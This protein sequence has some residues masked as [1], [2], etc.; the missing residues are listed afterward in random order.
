MSTALFKEFVSPGAKFRGSPFW[1][2]N[3]KLDPQRIR[4]QVNLM[5]E[6]GF[7]GFFMHSRA[8]LDTVYFSEEYFLS[9]S[10]A[11]DEARKLGLIPWLYDEDRWPSGFA[12]GRVT[13]NDTFKMKALHL[14]K[15]DSPEHL[16]GEGET[17][18]LFSASMNED[19]TDILSF[20]PF[21]AESFSGSNKIL[22]CF[23]KNHA[24]STKFNN[25]TYVDTLNPEAV[26]EFINVTHEEFKR[27]YGAEFG[28]LIPGIFT[29]EPCC[30]FT[31]LEA[32]P[33]TGKMLSAFQE[34]WHY[35]LTLYLPELFYPCGKEVSQVRWHFR[36]VVTTLFT[37]AFARQIGSWCEKNALQLT[38]HIQGEDYLAVQTA[39][40]GSPMRFYEHMHLPGVDLLTEHRNS[41]AGI[42][43]CVSSARQFGRKQRLS[44]LY[45]CTGWDFPL[46]GHKAL[47]DWQYALGINFRCHH[48]AFYTLAGEAKRDYP[49]SIFYQSPWY[50]VYRH[51]E[52]YFA[53]LSCMLSCGEEI[54]D[55]LVI[56]PLE[57][58]W[59][60]CSCRSMVDNN[61]RFEYDNTFLFLTRELLAQ[62]LDFDFGDE[63]QLSR[64]A[65]IE[66]NTLKVGHAS[67]KAVLI[68]EVKTLRKSTLRLLEDFAD[69][70]NTVCYCGE[71]PRFADAAPWNGIDRIFKKFTAVNKETLAGK[72]FSDRRISL[73]Q[74]DGKEARPL[75]YRL[76]DIDR[77]H[78]LFISNFGK[79]FSENIFEE[80]SVSERRET[81]PFIHVELAVPYRGNVYEFDA[82]S[83]NIHAVEVEY[84]EGKYLFNTSFDILESKLFVIS[85]I[86]PENVL[87]PRKKVELQTEIK[88]PF[89]G[90]DYS[91]SEPDVLVLDRAVYSSDGI[92]CGENNILEIDDALRNKLGA[93]CRGVAMP[94]PWLDQKMPEKFSDILLEFSFECDFVPAEDCFLAVENPDT[95]DFAVNGKRLESAGIRW[96]DQDIH[97]LR[98]PKGVLQKGRNIVTQ[99]GRFHTR[100]SGLEPIF[101][102]GNFGVDGRGIVPLPEKLNCSDWTQQ[103]LPHYSGNVT[104]RRTLSCIPDGKVYLSVPGWKGTALGIK[105]NGSE[106]KVFVCDPVQ[107]NIN[108]LLRRDGMDEVEITIYGHRR[109]MFGPFYLKN[110][111]VWTGPRQF[112]VHETTEKQLV[113]CG[114]TEQ[115]LLCVEK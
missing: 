59:S 6:M 32:V 63:E 17:V 31:T 27:R 29:D 64:L 33:W 89:D 78:T 46:A 14:E 52:D 110:P 4:H 68:P 3:G 113:P 105:V 23:W 15:A 85:E 16:S 106:E 11:I 75:L 70:G 41:F 43:Q 58:M 35:D 37:D 90:W 108:S 87:A 112:R 80:K 103:K 73:Q 83:G 49:A 98:I 36:E 60:I 9:V 12:G 97:L 34:K 20:E 8:G 66:N 7:G 111:P 74:P 45:A 76:G 71:I 51:I 96:I 77:G 40:A 102:L 62:H 101:I 30:F 92:T 95:F 47:G 19:E 61:T 65:S 38:G 104:Y 24:P 5:K 25:Q 109:N 56:H 26:A 18:A 79:E 81:F 22:R 13:Q 91:L 107:C 2:W 84:S 10:A 94:Q 67:Y 28:K 82:F 48:L 21:N 55:L 39:Y 72:L 86:P 99:K 42:K 53:R 93:A 100:L 54:R 44:E 115:V 50:K 57:S 69:R 88:L 114:L 1:A